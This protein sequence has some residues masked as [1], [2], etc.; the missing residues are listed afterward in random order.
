M[1][2][3]FKGKYRIAT[4][5]AQWWDY[6]NAGAYFVTICTRNREH[7][8]GKI[9]NGKMI[10]S[11]IGQIVE[12]EWI[13]TPA[14]RPDMQLELGAFIVMPNHFHAV[15][16]IK[17]NEYNSID[18][19]SV[20]EEAQHNDFNSVHI[21]LKPQS[22]N[23]SSIMRGF[24]SAVTTRAKKMG[25]D[26]F[27]WQTRFHDHIIRDQVAY[28]RITSYIINNPLNWKKDGFRN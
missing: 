4:A 12:E 17:N 27:G 7:F 9:E 8:F 5:R 6:A 10:L 25:H 18:L 2:Q 22:K 13:K 28:N 21:G 15:I 3:K 23:L 1:A 24:K 16:Q 20:G 19:R 11:S 14:L 26:H